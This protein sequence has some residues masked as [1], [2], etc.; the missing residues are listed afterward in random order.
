MH[1]TGV[2]EILLVEDNPGDVLLA[3]EALKDAKLAYHLD[4]VHDGLEAEEYLYRRGRFSQAPRPNLILLDLNLPRKNGWD[5]LSDL[6]SDASLRCIPLV[7]LTSSREEQDVLDGCDPARTLYLV[8]PTSFSALI[9]VFRQIHL[10]WASA[11]K[12]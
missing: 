5:V 11:M 7:V 1:N 2:M 9:E 4:V 8:K 10:F 12:N 3:E 6:Q